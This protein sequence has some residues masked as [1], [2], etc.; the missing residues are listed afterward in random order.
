MNCNLSYIFELY[1]YVTSRV[2]AHR[3]GMLYPF[4]M[5]TT[6]IL[7]QIDEQ[8]AKLQQAK[9]LLTVTEGK[10]KAGR[11]KGSKTVTA[12]SKPQKTRRR[13]S[14]EGKARIAAAQKARWASLKKI[15]VKKAPAKKQ[16]AVKT[17]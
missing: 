5:N 6:S 9:A 12:A 10:A 3:I 17:S 15:A 11:P 16:T 8:I 7:A 4:L 1:K 14:P 2:K 13:L